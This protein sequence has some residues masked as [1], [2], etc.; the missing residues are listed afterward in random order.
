M[1]L[2]RYI[3]EIVEQDLAE[4]MV[5]LFGPRQVGKTTLARIL[6]HFMI[7]P[8]LAIMDIGTNTKSSANC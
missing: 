4:K 5:F 3:R 8:K 2:P 6:T 1:Q 7:F